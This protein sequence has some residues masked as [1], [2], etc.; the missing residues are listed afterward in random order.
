MSTHIGD[1]WRAAG[2]LPIAMPFSVRNSTAP[3]P[4][5]IRDFRHR[6]LTVPPDR[7]RFGGGVRRSRSGSRTWRPYSPPAIGRGGAGAA[8]SPTRSPS[9]ADRARRRP[10]VLGLPVAEVDHGVPDRVSLS[11]RSATVNTM[12]C[13]TTDVEGAAEM[14]ISVA[15]STVR[16]VV[17][18]TPSR[19]VA[20]TVALVTVVST[21]R[22][23]PPSSVVATARNAPGVVLKDTETPGR[24]CWLASSTTGRHRNFTAYRG[25]SAGLGAQADAGH[26]RRADGHRGRLADRRA[27]IRPHVRHT[28]LPARRERRRNLLR[29]QASGGR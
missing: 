17:A 11:L 27:R 15:G 19:A 1:A 4:G 5:R 28:G 2:L 7:Q 23:W 20:A 29:G 12:A 21:V 16:V 26:C 24:G 18:C 3:G 22:A 10:E 9:S 6:L 13:P 25:Q 14:A 8:A